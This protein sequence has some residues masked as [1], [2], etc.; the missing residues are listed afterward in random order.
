[1]LI[2]R[3]RV[4]VLLPPLISILLEEKGC[5]VIIVPSSLATQHSTAIAIGITTYTLS[6]GFS[7]QT[8]CLFRTLQSQTL[9]QMHKSM[10]MVRHYES[11]APGL[12]L[13]ASLYC[14]WP[15]RMLRAT[16]SYASQGTLSCFS[17]CVCGQTILCYYIYCI[18]RTSYRLLPL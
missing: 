7:P 13:R 10:R 4:P 8:R 18:G 11:I 12:S 6:S 16:A 9:T 17:D 1:M 5:T 3:E 15:D 2:N 14:S